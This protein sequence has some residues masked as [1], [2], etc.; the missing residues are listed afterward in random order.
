MTNQ[1]NPS[2]WIDARLAEFPP[3]QRGALQGLREAIAAAAPE[4][5][6]VVSY[7][8]PAFRYH[9][10]MLVSYD[11]F[12]THCSLFP[13]SSVVVEQH[14]ELAAFAVAKGTYHFTAEHPIPP[15]RVAVVVRAR[16]SEI[17]A[18]STSATHRAKSE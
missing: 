7:K 10:R 12:K 17:D 5:E 14:P 1:V 16:M 8:M 18:R 15:R 2:D 9:G 13:M 3:A 6:E 4:A 11:G